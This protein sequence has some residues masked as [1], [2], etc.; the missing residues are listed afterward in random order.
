MNNELKPIQKLN[1]A[2]LAL[3]EAGY[4]FSMHTITDTKIY[5]ISNF[6]SRRRIEINCYKNLPASS[7]GDEAEIK[8]FKAFVKA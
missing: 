1:E 8:K 4:E 5:G 7:D 3:K 6:F 2:I